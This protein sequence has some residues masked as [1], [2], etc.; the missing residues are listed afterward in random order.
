MIELWTTLTPIL[1]A[2]VVNPVLFAFMVYAA[3]A[4]RPVLTSSMLLLGHTAAYLAAGFVVAL[5]IDKVSDRLANPHAIDFVISLVVG[6]LLLW[7]GWRSTRPQQKREPEA[8]GQLTPAKAFGFGAV[9]NFVGIPFALPYF[10][11]VDQMLKADL[12]TAG[13]VLTLVAYN[14]LYALPFVVVPV[15]VAVLGERSRPILDRINGVLE[16]ISKVMMPLL[17]LLIGLALIADAISYFVT[18]EGLV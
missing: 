7:V 6:L 4:G 2:D 8:S 13:A 15:L 5:G 9:V 1:L 18:G 16:R 17:L 11:A 3:G 10:A 14:I 12:A